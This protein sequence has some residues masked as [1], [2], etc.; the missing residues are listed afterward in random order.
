[1]TRSLT[2]THMKTV[3]MS[4][5]PTDVVQSYTCARKVSTSTGQSPDPEEKQQ[6]MCKIYNMRR[7]THGIKPLTGKAEAIMNRQEVLN[8]LTPQ[9]SEG[10]W[11]VEVEGGHE[12][13]TERRM[14]ETPR[15]RTLCRMQRQGFSHLK[16]CHGDNLKQLVADNS[17]QLV[18]D[19]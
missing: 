7:N 9:H 14:L 8:F 3:A 4:C 17:K 11:G 2:H 1:M 13:D 16:Y 6:I 10:G 18:A 15:A 19:N 5:A 12:P